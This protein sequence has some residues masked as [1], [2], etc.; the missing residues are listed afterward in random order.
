MKTVKLSLSENDI[1]KY[2]ISSDHLSFAELVEKIRLELGREA[3]LRCQE[4]AAKTG[5]SEMTPEEIDKEIKAVRDAK[6]R[7]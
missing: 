3:L 1:R 7:H 6:T 2:G 5:L 4:I